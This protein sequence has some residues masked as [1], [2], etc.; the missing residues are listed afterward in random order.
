MSSVAESK[1]RVVSA[2]LLVTADGRYL[3]QH[4]DD[5]PHIMLPGHWSC[6]G[7]AIEADE[8]PEAALRRELL[9]EIEFRARDVA[10]F[11]EM[12]VL[13]PLDP[14]RRDRMHFF[15]VPI[16]ATDLDR[17]VLHEGQGKALFTPEALAAEPRVAPWDLA[18]VLMHARRGALFPD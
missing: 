3:M 11:T 13:L 2:A 5:L 10:A 4:R 7:G 1:G 18:A 16:I 17:M 9:E 14:P 12:D 15:A 6:F 8:S